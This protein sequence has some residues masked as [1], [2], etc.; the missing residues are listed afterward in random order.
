MAK[1]NIKALQLEDE[2]N[3]PTHIRLPRLAKEN[4]NYVK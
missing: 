4:A 3:L 2:L 1:C